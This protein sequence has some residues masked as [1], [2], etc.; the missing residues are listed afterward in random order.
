MT[1]RESIK[2]ISSSEYGLYF[3]CNDYEVF[4]IL[5]DYINENYE[6]SLSYGIKEPRFE[7]FFKEAQNQEFMEQILNDFIVTNE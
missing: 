3:L 5:G 6:F 4:D 7:I 2:I 1:Y